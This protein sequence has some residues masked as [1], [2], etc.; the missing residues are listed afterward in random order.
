M[1]LQLLES[2]ELMES[3]VSTSFKHYTAF[4][5]LGKLILCK[6]IGRIFQAI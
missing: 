4:K 5:F 6:D 3:K 2:K 1:I